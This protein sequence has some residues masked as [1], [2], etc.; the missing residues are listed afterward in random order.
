MG[1][2]NIDKLKCIL[3]LFTLVLFLG[4]CRQKVH[5]N[6][7]MIDLLKVSENN[8]FNPGNV[9]SPGA[10]IKF[11][12]SVLHNSSD[13][14]VLVKALSDKAEALLK[15][16]QESKAIDTLFAQMIFDHSLLVHFNR[17][18]QMRKSK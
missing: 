15:L 5:P 12:D 10:M 16:G 14:E 4:S 8:D 11:S 18:H 6:Q 7:A 17:S 3:L 2:E 1:E 13:N 9:F